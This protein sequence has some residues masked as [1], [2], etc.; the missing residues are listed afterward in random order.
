M[1]FL[2]AGAGAADAGIVLAARVI[3]E[4]DV[5]FLIR[6]ARVLE[7]QEHRQDDDLESLAVFDIEPRHVKGPAEVMANDT[8]PRIWTE[9]VHVAPLWVRFSN[10]EASLAFPFEFVSG[11][12]GKPEHGY[13][14]IRQQSKDDVRLPFERSSKGERSGILELKEL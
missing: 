1:P 5:V 6:I 3:V 8:K 12:K 7:R 10:N 14:A 13:R 4:V 2:G 11:E 9:S